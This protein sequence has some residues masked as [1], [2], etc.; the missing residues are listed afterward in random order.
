MT[1]GLYVKP[2]TE[3]AEQ[4]RIEIEKRYSRGVAKRHK[5]VACGWNG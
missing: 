5:I 1:V 4:R 3:E 2:L